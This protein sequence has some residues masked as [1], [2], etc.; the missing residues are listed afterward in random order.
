MWR[1][2][3]WRLYGAQDLLVRSVGIQVG[4][5]KSLQFW[6]QYCVLLRGIYQVRKAFKGPQKPLYLA[7]LELHCAFPALLSSHVPH[8]SLAGKNPSRDQD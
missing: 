1:R 3:C 2:K 5:Q 6:I 7:L 8:S 4:N